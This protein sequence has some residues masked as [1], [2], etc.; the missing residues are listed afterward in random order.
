M[1]YVNKG[2]VPIVDRASFNIK[3][4]LSYIDRGDNAIR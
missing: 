4:L 1:E 3:E 2:A